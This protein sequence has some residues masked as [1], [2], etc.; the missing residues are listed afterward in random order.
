MQQVALPLLLAA[1]GTAAAPS[2]VLFF[3]M[4]A[5]VIAEQLDYTEQLTAFVFEGLV[6][7]MGA[8]SPTVM[9]KAGY[10]NYDWPDSDEYWNGWL[11]GQGRVKFTNVSSSTLCGLVTGADPHK[12]IEG[13]V[14]YDAGQR[15]EWA[16]PIATTVAGQQLLLPVTTAILA[17]HKCLASLKVGM[18]LTKVPEM[19]SDETAWAWAFKHLLPGASTTVAYNLYH[20]E[21][22]IH[23]DPQSNATLANV[24]EAATQAASLSTRY[25]G[26]VYAHICTTSEI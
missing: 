5:A 26:C 9:F 7:E 17:K 22:S 18:D 3:D 25:P 23:T 11:T 2:E 19:S 21:P 10:M 6:N 8:A 12:R 20:Y 15:E 24:D 13:V 14:L 1:T 16:L 4:D